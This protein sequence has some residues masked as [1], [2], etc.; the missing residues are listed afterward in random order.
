[1]ITILLTSCIAPKGI[2]YYSSTEYRK[3][4]YINALLFYVKETTYNIVFCDSSNIDISVD[5]NPD[6]LSQRVEILFFNGDTFDKKRGKG[7]G[8]A[9]IIEYSLSHSIYLKKCS[10]MIKIT[11]RYI[12]QNIQNVVPLKL[13]ANTL[14]VDSNFQLSYAMSYF[15]I[16]PKKFFIDYLLNNKE[17]MDDSKNVYFENVLGYTCKLWL[18]KYK[19][20]S[21]KEAIFIIGDTGST[22][23]KYNSPTRLTQIRKIIKYLL[24]YLRTQIYAIKHIKK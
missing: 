13:E 7:Y 1:M 17:K 14:L 11:G 19:I 8:E 2:P 15:F 22:G 4:Q 9:N 6:L 3:R 18:T 24:F 10:H 16:A 5:V 12:I 23:R 20:Y 21:F